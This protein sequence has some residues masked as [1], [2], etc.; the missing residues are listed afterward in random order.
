[1]GISPVTVAFLRQAGLDAVHLHE[2]QLDKLPDSEI[3]DKA[4][5]E[6]RVLLTSDLDFGDLLAASGEALPTVVVF[7]LRSMVPENVNRH[8]TMLLA[9]HSAE[10]EQGVVV[11]VA[12]DHIRTRRLPIE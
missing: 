9:Q 6:G 3:L 2:E 10:L 5:T 12:E 7:R 11:S 1:M 8:V 4:R